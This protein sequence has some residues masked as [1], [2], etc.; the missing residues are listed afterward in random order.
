MKLFF[1]TLL[2]LFC[3]TMSVAQVLIYEETLL[4]TSMVLRAE[5]DG[6]AAGVTAI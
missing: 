3:Y 4:M 2:A 6:V 1:T 5:V